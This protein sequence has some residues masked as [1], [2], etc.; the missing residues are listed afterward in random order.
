MSCWQ[1]MKNTLS[2]I[3][4]SPQQLEI[5]QKSEELGKSIMGVWPAC[6]K[7][8]LLALLCLAPYTHSQ[9]RFRACARPAEAAAVE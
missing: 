3:S 2:W 9:F 5:Q 7:N 4:P 1:N 6:A 8:E